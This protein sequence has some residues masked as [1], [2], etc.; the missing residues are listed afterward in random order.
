MMYQ[1]LFELMEAW[2][3]KLRVTNKEIATIML[4]ELGFDKMLA[5]E[6]DYSNVIRSFYHE[7]T[8]LSK[9]QDG[10]FKSW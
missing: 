4:L 6:R 8:S 1:I 5:R 2:D 9:I 3:D 10:G 7:K